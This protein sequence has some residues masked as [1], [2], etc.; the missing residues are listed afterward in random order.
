MFSIF[1]KSK[2]VPNPFAVLGTDMHNH[3]IPQ[4][5]DGSK[6]VEET[7]A[8]LDTMREVGFNSLYITPHFQF[9]F[10]NKEDDISQRY[11]ALQQDLKEKGVPMTLKGIGGEYR[12]DDTFAQRIED[13]KFLTVEGKVLVELSLHQV[14]MGV[15]ETLFDLGMKDRDIILAHPE[16]YPY[17]NAHSEVLEAL[18]E[19]GVFFQVNILSL[20]G[21]Y[22]D[23]AQR[24]A[25]E[26]I[27]KGWVEYLGTD[28]HNTT[29]AN[30]LR[31]AASDKKVQKVLAEHQFLNSQL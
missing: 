27:K 15:V 19:Q 10:P 28:M 4:V 2:T 1:K 23:V 24:N 3:L 7:M 6:S 9:R 12:I 13:N 22:G 26:F 17:Y 5:D 21:F 8:C 16:R 14:R 31:N 18:K 11:N 29:Y 25:F 30:A 20:S